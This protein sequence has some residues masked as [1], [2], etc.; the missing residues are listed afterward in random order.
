MARRPPKEY[1]EAAIQSIRASGTA[2]DPG[3]VAASTWRK[4][5]SAARAPWE[6]L[7]IVRESNPGPKGKKRATGS[8]AALAAIPGPGVPL[9]LAAKGAE[10]AVSVLTGDLVVI[11]STIPRGTKKNPLPPLEVEYHVNL[12]SIGLGAIGLG[13]A[14]IGGAIAW[15][16][17]HAPAPLGGSVTVIP[18]IR[19]GVLAWKEN[20]GRRREGR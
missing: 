19:D 1:M 8:V 7:R 6:A 10:T 17:L 14:A 5:S 15:Y 12:A 20:F 4:M 13:V 18:G 2:E 9:A 3:A 11:R 16:G